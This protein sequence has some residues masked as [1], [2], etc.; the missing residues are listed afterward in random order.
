[1]GFVFSVQCLVY[2]VHLRWVNRC[3]MFIDYLNFI[4]IQCL[5][6]CVSVFVICVR[7]TL[8]Y[9]MPFVLWPTIRWCTV[10]CTLSNQ[11]RNN[12][13][14]HCSVL[15]SFFFSNLFSFR[16]ALH[17]QCTIQNSV[18][19]SERNTFDIITFSAL[20]VINLKFFNSFSVFFLF[21]SFLSPAFSLLC[22][23]MFD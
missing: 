1:M 18:L 13:R 16:N 15:N 5:W 9:M 3:T 20:Y 14:C 7:C 2:L 4:I 10:K 22:I 8:W 21:S 19:N 12:E 23:F 6:H 17:V 11:I